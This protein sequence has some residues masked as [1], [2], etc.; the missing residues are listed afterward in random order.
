MRIDLDKRRR[1]SLGMEALM[2]LP[3]A[4]I[5]ILLGRFIFES[6][7]TRHEVAVHV[8]GSAV[9]AAAAETI[10]NCRHESSFIERNDVEKSKLVG[11]LPR[12]GE[13]GL[14]QEKKIMRAMED[15]ASAWRQIMRDIRGE[16]PFNDYRSA[17]AGSTAFKDPEFL[18]NKGTVHNFSQHMV[19]TD[20][21]F[22]H[23]GKP[24]DPAHD[25]VVWDELRKKG[26][27][28]LFPRLFPSRSGQ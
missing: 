23:G 16:G 28:R 20:E 2:I 1:G 26:S 10:V 15:S 4:I 13:R 25:P 18:E 7:M 27:Y 5:M 24:W 21:V 8:R 6:A 19:T 22:D 14:Q 17:G 3:F 12:D 9:A 11:C